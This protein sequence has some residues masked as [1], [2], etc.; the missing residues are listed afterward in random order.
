MRMRPAIPFANGMKN[1]KIEAVPRRRPQPRWFW[2]RVAAVGNLSDEA[3]EVAAA[4]ALLPR[5]R[6]APEDIVRFLLDLDARYHR[7]L[8]QD[9]YG[10]TRAD[11]SA[12]LM[13]LK[14]A[15]DTLTRLSQL[16]PRLEHL[17]VSRLSEVVLSPD[18]PKRTSAL[19]LN[20]NANL[21]N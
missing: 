19:P 4:V 6:S 3:G 11:R 21:W 18:A 7:Y 2:S 5:T 10:P 9:E 8:H 12:A 15:L 13:G 20:G 1:S 17:L 16:P 14:R